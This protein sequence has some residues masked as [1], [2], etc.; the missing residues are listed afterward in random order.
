MDD[1]R[2]AHIDSNLEDEQRRLLCWMVESERTIPS[3]QHGTFWLVEASGES[4]LI[5]HHIAERPRVRPGDLASLAENSVLRRI[6]DGGSKGYEIT[7]RGRSYY[8]A[9]KQ[10]AGEPIQKIT[11]EVRSYLDAETFQVGFPTAYERWRSAENDLWSAESEGNLTK[12]GHACREA[13]QAF[14]ANAVEL[15]GI[16][17]TSPDPA[18]TV[19]RIRAVLDHK[20]CTGKR[21]EFLDALLN[22]WGTV[23]DLVQRQEHGAG[24]E[25]EHLTWE[26]TRIIVFHT[27]IA[28]SEIARIVS[29]KS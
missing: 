23:S 9:L 20:H 2:L 17:D 14:A 19:A 7:P 28:M 13:M 15:L 18:K 26:D 22:Y 24:K 10:Q 12:I 21:R 5:H 16:T 8:A 1:K 4:F 6:Y 3:E 29:A 27:M 25:G 11:Q